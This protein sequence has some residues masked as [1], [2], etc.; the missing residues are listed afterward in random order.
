MTFGSW[1]QF[2]GFF[3]W[4][5]RKIRKYSWLMPL[6]VILQQPSMTYTLCEWSDSWESVPQ[7]IWVL[8]R[9][10]KG[11]LYEHKGQIFD[12]FQFWWVSKGERHAWFN[13]CELYSWSMPMR[14]PQD[15]H[16]L[17]LM[18]TDCY[19]NCLFCSLL[20][21]FCL[22]LRK[23]HVS[24]KKVWKLTS[25]S[26]GRGEVKFWPNCKLSKL[27]QKIPQLSFRWD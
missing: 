25:T 20:S 5:T 9:G 7:D 8:Q 6:Q 16:P 12:F 11:Q 24:W 4:S 14:I 23:V 26:R 21:F 1:G 19:S 22:F 18:A 3:E 10:S 17:L 27:A 15:L 13:F 2:S